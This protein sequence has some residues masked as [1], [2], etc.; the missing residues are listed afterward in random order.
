MDKLPYKI[1]IL[2]CTVFISLGGMS[3]LFASETMVF[4]MTAQKYTFKP[5]TIEVNEGDNVTLHITSVDT[6]HGIGIEEYNVDQ[7]LP[8]GETITIEFIADK[9]GKFEIECTKFCG[10]LHFSM[11]N[12]LIVR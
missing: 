8:K 7:V 12:T 2:L 10:W 9:K 1:I 3:N 5:E 4:K 6:K 11:T